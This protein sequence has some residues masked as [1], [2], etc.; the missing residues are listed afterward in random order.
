MLACPGCG[1]TRFSWILRQVQFGTVHNFDGTY[2][3]EGTKR[4]PVTG[5]DVDENGVF[6]VNC[7]KNRNHDDLVPYEEDEEDHT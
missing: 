6:C 4:G 5:S 3:E 1:G 2:A 7:Q